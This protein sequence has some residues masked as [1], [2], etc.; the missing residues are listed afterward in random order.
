M[1][2]RVAPLLALALLA[3]ACRG[4]EPRPSPPAPQVQASATAPDAIRVTWSGTG[5]PTRWWVLVAASDDRSV[6]QRTACGSCRAIDVAHL[7]PGSRYRIRVV[8][9][10]ATEG[11]GAFSAPV[12][13]STPAARGCEPVAAGTTCVLLDASAPGPAATGV[14]LGVLHGVTTDTPPALFAPL[15]PTSWRVA[16]LDFERFAAARR[17]GGTVT[18]LLSD[19][20]VQVSS[21]APW[22]D[23]GAYRS[24]VA[25]TVAAQLAAGALPDQWDVQNEP[26]PSS[27]PGAGRPPTPDLVAEQARVAA[28]EIHRILPGAT[29]VGPSSA[30][31][32]F[33]SGPAD[34]EV[35]ARETIGRGLPVAL[36]WH[37]IGG[38][39]LGAC[40]GGPRAVLQHVD[41]ARAML[42]GVP[43]GDAVRLEVNEW[44]APWNARQPGATVGY[45]S[46]LAYAGVELANPACWPQRNQGSMLD[47]CR[48][49][50]GTLDGLLEPDG[51]T[52]SDVWFVHA[53]YAAMTGAGRRLLPV[54]VA[55]PEASAV[56][57]VDGQG[58]IDVLVGRHTGCDASVDDSC[59]A[60]VR[61]APDASLRLLVAGGATRYAVAI[62]TIASAAGPSSGAT[63]V[64]TA[65]VAAAGGIVDLGTV[66]LADGAALVV[67]LRPLG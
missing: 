57:T 22:D 27:F 7:A 20:W 31:P 29:V 24:F 67:S 59:P 56:A 18:V 16:A 34:L 8:A 23:W 14:G 46:S 52:P 42:R 38:S 12:E 25:Q 33:G 28:E 2:R 54:S 53:A 61:Y 15:R 44:G 3:A 30:Y 50:P 32:T 65:E 40:D 35:F 41:D 58:A 39:C 19:A 49:R 60:G 51:R 1:R 10:D 17:Y 4:A 21:Q 6:G 11:F 63:P 13:V 66:A 5:E 62:A 64:R 48:S 45:L 9:V 26:G 37:E 47:S 55:D 43:G 36:S